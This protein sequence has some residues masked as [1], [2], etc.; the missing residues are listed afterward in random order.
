MAYRIKRADPQGY[1]IQRAAPMTPRAVSPPWDEPQPTPAPQ[2][3]LAPQPEPQPG[4]FDPDLPTLN[5][6]I[7]QRVGDVV[8]GVAGAVRGDSLYDLPELLP[9]LGQMRE[10]ARW[11]H[12]QQDGLSGMPKTEETAYRG[13]LLDETDPQTF[14]ERADKVYQAL[15]IAVHPHEQRAIIKSNFP[16]SHFYEDANGNPYVKIPKSEDF[17]GGDFAVNISGLS[18]QDIVPV[19]TE[20]ALA[21]YPGNVAGRLGRKLLGPA[22]RAAGVGTTLTAVELA[23]MNEIRKAVGGGDVD[24]NVQKAMQLGGVAALIELLVPTTL[25]VLVRTMRSAGRRGGLTAEMRREL[26]G[27][28]LDPSDISED[29][30]KQIAEIDL[31]TP[32]D[33]AA[34]VRQAGAKSLPVPVTLTPGQA[35]QDVGLLFDEQNAMTMGGAEGAV[36]AARQAGQDALQANLP[37]IQTRLTGQPPRAPGEAA[38]VVQ[39]TLAA[40]RGRFRDRVSTRYKE[41]EA[42]GPAWFSG[43][44]VDELENAI[45][46]SVAGFDV[47]GTP[48]IHSAIETFGTK[49][50]KGAM[51]SIGTMERWRTTISN[52]SPANA[53]E[54]SIKRRVLKAY[55]ATV[56]KHITEG[57]MSGN[58]EVVLKWRRS[59]ALRRRFG[60]I[61]EQDDLIDT[62]TARM[63]SGDRSVLVVTPDEAANYLFGRGQL[64]ANKGMSRELTKLRRVL[65]AN[66]QEWQAVRE[67]AFMRMFR[68]DVSGP[69]ENF[70]VAYA[71]NFTRSMKD[72]PTVMRF[73][74][75]DRERAV[76]RQLANTA[77]A[78][79]RAPRGTGVNVQASGTFGAALRATGRLLGMSGDR[80]SILVSMIPGV[81]AG[82]ETAGVRAAKRTAEGVLPRRP[83]MLG[84]GVVSMPVAAGFG[85]DIN[86][87]MNQMGASLWDRYNRQNPRGARQ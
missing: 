42:M 27:A 58:P 21:T 84:P 47:P 73:L 43:K 76:F 85:P 8:R 2:P 37:A 53:T 66:S 71:D 14:S 80:L 15:K 86:T 83:P 30:R 6:T 45:R 16:G 40:K 32:S 68:R 67:E 35:T 12:Y 4:E 87:L 48:A 38:T 74:F 9:S 22:G 78:A 18:E 46:Q 28:R 17:P 82:I 54:A 5:R 24:F 72:S 20:V 63:Q 77:T 62:L 81:K 61:F 10:A 13:T 75:T 69:G 31:T 70:Y 64:G 3:T 56:K 33:P 59:V 49:M 60:Q 52:V 79:G 23:R 65:G 25:R 26:R 34:V 36:T 39:D 57:L 29:F 51:T 55:D 19:A 44:Q 7:P 11:R 1:T 50:P 41:A